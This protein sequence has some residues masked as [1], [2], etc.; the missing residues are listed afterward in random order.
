MGKAKSI[1]TKITNRLKKLGYDCKRSHGYRYSSAFVSKNGQYV[2]I[3]ADDDREKVL[4]RTAEN[5]QDFTG[6]Q[7]NFANVDLEGNNFSEALVLVEK[8]IKR[9]VRNA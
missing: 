7:N 4:I 9:G 3:S 2:Y 5:E 1:I 6:G 8:L